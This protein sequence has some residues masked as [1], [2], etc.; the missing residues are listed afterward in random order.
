VERLN[1]LVSEGNQILYG[2]H[3]RPARPLAR[4]VLRDFPR[5]VRSQ[6]RGLGVCCLIFYGLAVFSCF[7][8]I[9]FP[10]LIYELLP[11]SRILALEDMYDP[12]GKHFLLPRDIGSDADMFG[13]YIYNNI[14]I[15]FRTFAGGILAGIGS[16]FMLGVN[17]LFLGLSA[18]HIINRGFAGTFF[19]FIIAHGAFELTAMILS[20]RGGLILGYSLFITRGLSRGASLRQAGKEALPLI[21]GAALL[22]VLAAAVEAFWSFRHGFPLPLRC[23]V[24]AAAWVL[25]SAYFALAGR[26]GIRR[27]GR[28]P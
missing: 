7:L 19:P 5:C 24:G 9:R 8:C 21:S 20:A 13:F 4:F 22:L 27:E 16:L 23:A 17:A 26:G 28:R 14:S 6:W 25:M 12:G 1:Y 15:A 11:E 10:G 3:S 2:R 18:G